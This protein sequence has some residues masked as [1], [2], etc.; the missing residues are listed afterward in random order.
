MSRRRKHEEHEEHADESWLIPYADLMTLLLALFIVLFSMSSVDAKRFDEM[1]RAFNMALDG[2]VGVLDNFR[3]V[4]TGKDLNDEK[5]REKSKQEQKQQT[6]TKTQQQQQQDDLEKL[7][8]KE[9]EDLEKLKKQ[10]DQYIK[11]MGLT[12][13]LDTKLNQSQLLITISD[14][15]LYAS[16]S[17]AVKPESRKLGQAIA[18]MLKQYPGYEIIVAG[19]TD[20]QPISNSD[21]RDNWDLSSDRA[22]NFMQ[23]LLASAQL[24]PK[25]ISST[26]YGEFRPLTSNATEAGR[27]KNRRVEVSLMR[28]Y[29]D[30]SKAATAAA[31]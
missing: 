8:K 30:P 5:E 12:T 7:R 29:I 4:Q 13:Q 26:G 25:L 23:I 11:S 2:G 21:F 28:K 17:S 9:Q 6:V 16:G 20:N 14:N 22:L 10:L 24:D 1:S 3:S 18:K 31:K 15:A 27:S 19:H